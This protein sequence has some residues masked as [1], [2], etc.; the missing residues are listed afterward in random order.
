MNGALYRVHA[1]DQSDWYDEEAIELLLG[2]ALHDA[3]DPGTFRSIGMED[4]IFCDD[5]TSEVLGS[6]LRM[7]IA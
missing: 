3:A 5:G 4:M 6:E 7:T 1:L 2:G